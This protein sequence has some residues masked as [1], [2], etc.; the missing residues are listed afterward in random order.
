MCGFE[1]GV[2]KILGYGD[3]CIS[4]SVRVSILVELPREV[5]GLGN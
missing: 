1:G 4:G 5:G 2:L 3:D